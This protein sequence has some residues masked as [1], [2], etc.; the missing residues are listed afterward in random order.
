MPVCCFDETGLFGSLAD[1]DYSKSNGAVHGSGKRKFSQVSVR[2]SRFAFQRRL[3]GK[4]AQQPAH[5]VKHT[6]S[7]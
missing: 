5:A 6:S 1:W 2:V 3:R 4:S 7:P